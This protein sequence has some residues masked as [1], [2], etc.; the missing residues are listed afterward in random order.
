MQV[1]LLG[2]LEVDGDDGRPVALG[3]RQAQALLGLLAVEANRLGPVSRLID[4]LWA[5]IHRSSARKKVQTYVSRLRAALGSE[6]CELGGSAT[7]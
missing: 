5:T 1:R 6:R 4:E 3:G 7:R 2:P